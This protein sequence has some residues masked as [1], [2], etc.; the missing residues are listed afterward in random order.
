M[1]SVTNGSNGSY[2]VMCLDQA[3]APK[4]GCRISALD[5]EGP[6]RFTFIYNPLVVWIVAP[7]VI[8]IF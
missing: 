2:E 1:L 7:V 4:A 5:E 8:E 3:T 6:L